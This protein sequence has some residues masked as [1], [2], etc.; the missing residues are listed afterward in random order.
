M[1][2]S[3]TKLPPVTRDKRYAC[4]GCPFLWESWDKDIYPYN[5]E[6]QRRVNKY[7]FYCTKDCRLKKIAAIYDYTGLVPKWCPRLE[8]GGGEG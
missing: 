5:L 6:R 2:E 4:K 1:M 3:S 8:T 7:T